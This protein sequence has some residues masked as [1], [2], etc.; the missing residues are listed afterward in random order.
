MDLKYDGKAVL[1]DDTLVIADTHLGF[2]EELQ[3]GNPRD[4]YQSFLD[5]LTELVHTHKPQTVVIAG[6]IFDSFK[7]PPDKTLNTVREAKNYINSQGARLV[8]TP[9]NHDTDAIPWESGIVDEATPE[10]RVN[11]EVVI[12]HGHKEP[13]KD[14]DLY[15][16]G[17]L[18]PT[19]RIQTQKWP[20]YLYGKNAYGNSDVLILPKFTE[21]SGGAAI[22]STYT[23][24]I[25]FPLANSFS[26]FKPI[27]WDTNERETREFPKL[28]D[29]SHKL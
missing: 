9:G 12:L 19:V 15:I 3:I 25:D 18:H 11:Q 8:V 20:C 4:E 22:S 29:F 17:H 1:V 27:V 21:H 23:P 5:A 28:S 7:F 16:I 2:T 6:D 13:T 10:Y 14:A 24:E 26:E